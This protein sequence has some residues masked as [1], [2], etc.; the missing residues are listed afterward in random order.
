M[1]DPIENKL[2]RKKQPLYSLDDVCI[3]PARISKVR[4]RSECNPLHEN[5]M[6]PI[7]AAPMSTVIS[8]WNY[9]YFKNLGII[10]I[11]PRNIDF[12]IRKQRF[13]EGYCVAVS[14]DEFESLTTKESLLKLKTVSH[15]YIQH[16]LV[17]IANGHME[18][19]HNAII[20][21]KQ[22]C[23]TVGVDVEI[24]AGNV[25]SPE[26][27]QALCEAGAD[28]VRCSVGSGSLCSTSVQTG[29]H[30]P[31]ASLIDKCFKIKETHGYKTLIIADGGISSYDR[32][33]KALAL[34]ADYVMIGTAF[35]KAF[36]S[37]AD[38]Y[39]NDNWFTRLFKNR[40]V[41]LKMKSVDNNPEKLKEYVKKHKLT[42]VVFGM[43]T[44]N[45]QKEIDPKAKKLKT[46]EGVVR[47]INVEYT[48]HQWVENFKDYLK[49]AMS[50]TGF[51]DL[52][53]FIGGP[54]IS[55][56]TSLGRNVYMK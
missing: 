19:L 23:I 9:E 4:H 25:A 40:K 3:I 52:E 48:L 17:D 18:A 44:R 27:F 32:A 43:S 39:I 26:A 53:H 16:I 30:Y 56:M 50:Y 6:L 54:E 20:V 24:I 46:S 29:I 5:Q 51:T 11:L 8:D 21:A 55:V 31:L 47:T 12:K 42:K 37:A 14:L 7:F 28:A 34:G 33:I 13:I 36:E 1:L 41:D 22:N 49:S 2:T 38:Y 35:G 10:P 15:T 45:A